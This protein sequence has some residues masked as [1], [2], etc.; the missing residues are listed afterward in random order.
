MYCGLVEIWH[1]PLYGYRCMLLGRSLWDGSGRSVSGRRIRTERT[2]RMMR[3]VMH[4]TNQL[5]LR[6]LLCGLWTRLCSC[7][8]LPVSM[9]FVSSW[10]KDDGSLYPLYSGHRA[11]VWYRIMYLWHV[12]SLLV[13]LID[14]RE[15]ALFFEGTGGAKD[16]TD[17]INKKWKGNRSVNY[18]VSSGD[19]KRW[20]EK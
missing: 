11:A 19:K 6:L 3:M 1:F 9:N 17:C 2:H 5:N 7:L 12:A 10:A 20:K 15:H 16:P 8:K 13:G 4:R 14:T 18:K